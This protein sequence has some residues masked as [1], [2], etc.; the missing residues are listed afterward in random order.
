MGT[1]VERL[2]MCPL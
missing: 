1:I 2:F